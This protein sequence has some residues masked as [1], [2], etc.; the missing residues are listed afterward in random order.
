MDRFI[1]VGGIMF[2]PYVRKFK[3]QYGQIYRFSGTTM[4]ASDSD[5]KSNM[6][7]FIE[8]NPANKPFPRISLKSNMDRFIVRLKEQAG[9]LSISLKSNMDRFIGVECH[10]VSVHLYV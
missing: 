9:A 8:K 5:L 6:D 10:F 2:K 4:R 3:I 1:A 7:R